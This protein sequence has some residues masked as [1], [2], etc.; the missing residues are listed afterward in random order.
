MPYRRPAYA[1][2]AGTRVERKKEKKMKTKKEKKKAT[3]EERGDHELLSA[4][5]GILPSIVQYIYKKKKNLHC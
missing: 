2:N 3:K 5:P 4:T 1:S